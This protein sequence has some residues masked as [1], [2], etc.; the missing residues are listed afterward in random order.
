[1][2]PRDAATRPTLT[3]ESIVRA[4]LDLGVDRF[5]MHGVAR[6]LGVSAT[7]LYRHVGSRDELIAL[8]MDTL[9]TQIEMPPADAEWRSYL[10]ALANE[11]R[12]TLRAMPGAADYGSKIGPATPTALGI[13]DQALGVLRDAG[14]SGLGAWRAYSLV[15]NY[16]FYAVQS[17]E[18]FHRLEAEHGAGGFRVFQLRP[19]EHARFPNVAWSTSDFDFDFDA[20]FA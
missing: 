3:P 6:H 9:C 7:A 17:E 12:R 4:V 18:H 1:M 15:V 8:A 5:S 14:F 11:F 2:S 10:T 19:E 13:V 20:S 16:A